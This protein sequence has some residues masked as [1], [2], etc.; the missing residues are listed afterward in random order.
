MYALNETVAAI[1]KIVQYIRAAAVHT[2]VG[3]Y[4]GS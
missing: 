2:T 3:Q 1:L 4:H